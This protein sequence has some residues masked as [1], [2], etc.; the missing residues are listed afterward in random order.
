[1]SPWATSIDDQSY[2]HDVLF[3]QA[4]GNLSKSYIKQCYDEGLEYPHYLFEDDSR[5]A[6]PSQSLNALTVGSISLNSFESNDE[7]SIETVRKIRKLGVENAAEILSTRDKSA[8][9]VLICC[10]NMKEGHYKR[11]RPTSGLYHCHNSVYSEEIYNS[12]E[13]VGK[14]RKPGFSRHL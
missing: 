2:E 1:M 12:S 3:I 5:I 9:L 8:A 14:E 6:N 13:I 4:T 10:F 7:K 11:K